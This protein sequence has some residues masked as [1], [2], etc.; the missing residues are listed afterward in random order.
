LATNIN[1]ENGCFVINNKTENTIPK[2]FNELIEELKEYTDW[3]LFQIIAP[4]INFKNSGYKKLK[5][6]ALDAEKRG[7]IKTKNNDLDWYMIKS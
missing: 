2:I 4:K 6:F 5:D 7:Y 3:I 1:F